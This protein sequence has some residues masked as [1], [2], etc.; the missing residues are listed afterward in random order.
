MSSEKWNGKHHSC[1][2]VSDTGHKE[3]QNI[4]LIFGATFLFPFGPDLGSER[5]DIHVVVNDYKFKDCHVNAHWSIQVAW[6]KHKTQSQKWATVFNQS[7]NWMIANVL[8]RG[9]SCF[10][11][12]YFA[13]LYVASLQLYE[14]CCKLSCIVARFEVTF[15]HGFEASVLDPVLGL[16]LQA[17][18]PPHYPLL[19][20]GIHCD[21]RGPTHKVVGP[22]LSSFLEKDWFPADR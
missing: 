6:P 12:N 16:S 10:F 8:T 19:H 15:R 5:S 14:P 1:H 11:G 20:E 2:Q 4:Q 17:S 18:Y 7:D 13:S 3:Q 21:L 22:K 9:E